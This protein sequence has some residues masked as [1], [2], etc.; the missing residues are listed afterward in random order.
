MRKLNL[1][2]L[3]KAFTKDEDGNVAMMTAVSSVILLGGLALALDGSRAVNAQIN[4]ADASDSIALMLAK[5]GLE[6]DGEMRAAAQNHLDQLYPGGEGKDVGILAIVRD[7]DSVTVQLSDKRDTTFGRVLNSNE[8]PVAA[9][10]TA[11]FAEREMD[12][13]LVLDTTLSME[14]NKLSSLQGA[15]TSM[16]ETIEGYES[17]KVRMSVVPFSNYV[18]VGLSRRNE[19]WLR[20]DPDSQSTNTEC[21]NVAKVISR[22]NCRTVTKTCDRDGVKS[23]CKQK[24]CDVK[25]GKPEK[26]CKPVT[27]K[28]VWN[29]CV[30][31]RSEPL[32][33]TPGF[34]GARIPGLLNARCGA[35]IQPLTK[36][37]KSVKSTI[38]SL[39][40]SGNTYMPAGLVWGWRTLDTDQP[41]ASSRSKADRVLILMTDGKNSRSKSGE[42]HEQKNNT[43][44][45]DA[46]TA[47]LCAGIKAEEITV[48]TIA[49]EV[50]DAGTQSLLNTCASG[51]AN[52]FNAR[53]A[54]EL[55][56][57]FREI[58]ESLNEL[59]ITA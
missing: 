48:Y 13:A 35:E 57:A 46:K 14:G 30:G 31:S 33:T 55:E 39:S 9:S 11:V 16:V 20:V 58:G 45:A 12:I 1:S 37:M 54:S 32:D 17:A 10:A 29:G 25:R 21:R 7:G 19:P 52:F 53:N 56:R 44:A 22:T 6:N 41:L 42:W 5:S 47:A 26:V 40:A 3:C 43:R 51:S 24:I 28:K 2:R 23:T 38:R 50:N 49:Y 34:R 59:R 18:N 27:R 8:I 4:L 36:N 15:A